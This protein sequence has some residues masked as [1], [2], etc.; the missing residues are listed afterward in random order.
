M[1]ATLARRGETTD[2]EFLPEF[3]LQLAPGMGAVSR[4]VWRIDL[5]GDDPFPP[6]FTC[7]PDHRSAAPSR[8]W[9]EPDV[10]TDHPGGRSEGGECVAQEMLQMGPANTPRLRQERRRPIAQQI[11]RHERDGLFVDE[12]TNFMF[13]AKV[14]SSLEP[15]KSG[16]CIP[17][18][19]NNLPIENEGVTERLCHRRQRDH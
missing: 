7:A 19:G 8:R 11:E 17:Y 12:G 18:Q 2:D 16:R 13:G 6:L 9:R 1:L 4:N 3:D 5:L 14:H 15:L 10:T